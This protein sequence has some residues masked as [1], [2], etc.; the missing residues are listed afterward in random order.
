M[1][2]PWL[3]QY[4]EGV[5]DEINPD[6]YDSLVQLIETSFDKFKDREAYQNMGKGY[7]YGYLD[8]QTKNFAAYLQNETDLVPGDRVAIQMPN[9]LQYPIAMFGA[10]RAGMIIVNTNPLYTAREMKHQFKD[11]GAKALIVVN[12]FADKVEEVLADTDIKYVF[13]T[14]IGDFL[15]FPKKGIINFVIKNVKKMEPK[16][17]LPQAISFSKVLKD[18]SAYTF[19]RPEINRDDV[20]FLQYTGGTT[21]VS[22]GAMLTHRNLIANLLQNSAWMHKELKESPQ[23]IAITALPLYHVFSLT[24]NCLT[25]FRIGAKNI[26]ITNPR[27]IPGFIKELSKHKFTM[28]SGV[29]TLFNAMMN[30]PKFTQLDFS[31]LKITIGGG[32]AVQSFV[33]NKWKELTGVELVEGYGLTETSPTASCNPLDGSGQIG[34]IGIP[35]PST[36]FEIRDDEGNTLPTGEVGEICIKGP[37]VMKGYW[38]RE[39]DTK[40]TFWPEEWLKTGDIGVMHEDGY[41][42]IVDRKK[43]MIL[44]SGFN[45]YPNEIE[46]VVSLHDGVLEVAAVGVPDEKST[47]AVKIFVVKADENLTAEDLKAFCKENLTGYKVPK[48]YEF[49]EDLPKTNVGKILRRELRDQ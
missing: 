46:E 23:E 21:G 13:T 9:L 45:V 18:G 36:S 47:E 33:A 35:F 32:M 24:V 41:F 30:D 14:R 19:T 37:Q 40:D 26:L 29:N 42:K 10:L 7:T 6:Q 43:D 16:F 20:A 27:D 8:E 44:V 25:M 28:V 31:S 12:N 15:G 17:N 39:E 5:V 22:K 3:K 4:P 11:S 34:T 49:R 48:H 38:Q 2:K 1:N